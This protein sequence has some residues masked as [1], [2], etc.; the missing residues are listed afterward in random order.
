MKKFSIITA[1]SAFF[2]LM[3]FYF[4]NVYSQDKVQKIDEYIQKYSELGQ[5][6]G[7]VLVAEDGNILLSKIRNGGF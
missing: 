2:I 7:A 3:L 6:N 1:K 4:G 5:F